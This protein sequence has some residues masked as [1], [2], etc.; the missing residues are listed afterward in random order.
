MTFD[1][2]MSRIDLFSRIA[3]LSVARPDTFEAFSSIIRTSR[4]YN[5]GAFSDIVMKA[6]YE[7]LRDVTGQDEY[8]LYKIVIMMDTLAASR[9][10]NP[11]SDAHYYNNHI[12]ILDG[13]ITNLFSVKM[14]G[15]AENVKG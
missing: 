7:G 11:S 8:I 15:V 13:L 4:I 3:R 6:F 5:C 2:Y 1:H 14:M 12:E 9:N 10:L